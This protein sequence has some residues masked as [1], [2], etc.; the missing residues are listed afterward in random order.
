M[1]TYGNKLI[2]GIQ[3]LLFTFIVVLYA[4]SAAYS[5]QDGR[6]QIKSMV[7]KLSV[8]KEDTARLQLFTNIIQQYLYYDPKQ[9]LTYRQDALRLAAKMQWKAGTALLKEKIG[10]LHW[11]MGEN[12]AAVQEHFDALK[13]YRQLGDRPGETRSLKFIG[14]NYMDAGKQAAAEIYLKQSLKLAETNG[15]KKGMASAYNLLSDHYEAQ[16]NTVE[17]YNAGYAYLKIIEESKDSSHLTS[18]LQLVGS[19]LGAMGNN[20]EAIKY[21]KKALEQATLNG[22]NSE[23]Q[24]V[25]MAMGEFYLQTGDLPAAEECYT[26]I[27]KLVK[28]TGDQRSIGYT[29]SLIGKVYMQMR[30]Y[31]DALREL[32][33]AIRISEPTGYSTRIYNMYSDVGTVYTMLGRYD[34]ARQYFNK[35]AAVTKN[36]FAAGFRKDYYKGLYMLDSA[37]GN[38]KD[39]YLYYKKYAEL[40]DSTFNQKS[41]KKL[42]T[43]QLQYETDKKEA[44]A[45]VAQEKK[46]LLMQEEVKRQRNIR[47]AAFIGLGVV[48]L[49][50]VLVFSQRNKIA[51]EKKRSDQLVQD[52]ELLLREIHHRVKNNLEIVSSLLALQSAQIDDQNTKDAMQEGQ[53]RVQSIGIVHQKLYQGENL[54]TIEMKDYFINLSESILDSFGAEDRVQVKC[55]MDAIDIDIDT[56]VP[57]GLIVNELLTNTL[58]YAFPD[59]RNGQVEIKLEKRRDGIL[60]LLVSDNGVGKSGLTKGTGFG[61]QLVSLLTRQLNGSMTEENSNGTHILF[62]FKLEKAA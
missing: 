29:Y 34:L 51:R 37:T 43:S 5:Q 2:S 28:E 1:K 46:D 48:I 27:L 17:A 53:N 54:G 62:E 20:T 56:A 11:G 9:G 33:L 23:M 32:L 7:A 4:F 16:A 12:E 24:L 58:K 10:R 45:K 38:W 6:E 40:K 59:S 42:V 30:K 39:A 13:L 41:L 44:I 15:D 26:T 18:A 36:F 60:Q 61:G 14:Q 52:K 49:F 35:V 22:S 3:K 8:T 50:S 31:E 25:N 19:N 57:L 47:N 55:A 21:F